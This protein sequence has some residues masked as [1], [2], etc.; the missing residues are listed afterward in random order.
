[1][2]IPFHMVGTDI[3]RNFILSSSEFLPTYFYA[4]IFH[5]FASF[6][7]VCA[8][9]VA[10]IPAKAIKQNIAAAAAARQKYVQDREIPPHMLK[11]GIECNKRLWHIQKCVLCT[12]EACVKEL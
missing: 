5:H 10:L 8:I 3:V 4:K 6:N 2:N 7:C 11:V 9:V 1:M 12:V